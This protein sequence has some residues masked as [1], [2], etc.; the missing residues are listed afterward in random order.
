MEREAR[1][2]AVE[3]H[4]LSLPRINQRGQ[5][6]APALPRPQSWD[7]PELDAVNNY[8]ALDVTT[9]SQLPSPKQG[10]CAR[11]VTS[12]EVCRTSARWALRLARAGRGDRSAQHAAKSFSDASATCKPRTTDS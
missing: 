5:T 7:Q 3:W 8:L 9:M 10:P 6:A 2:D 11:R 1:I 4:P 12:T